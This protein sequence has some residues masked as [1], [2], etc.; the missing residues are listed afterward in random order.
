VRKPLEARSPGCSTKRNGGDPNADAENAAGLF[1]NLSGRTRREC[2][3]GM[4]IAYQFFEG[5]PY[6]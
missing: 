3:G 1:V 4:L 2:S 5:T 6:L